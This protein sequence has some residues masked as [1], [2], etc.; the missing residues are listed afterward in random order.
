LQRF[1]SCLFSTPGCKNSQ[2]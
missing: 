1:F 2:N